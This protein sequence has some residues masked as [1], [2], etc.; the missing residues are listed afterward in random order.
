MVFIII[1]AIAAIFWFFQFN[2]I[3]SHDPSS[4]KDEQAEYFAVL[5]FKPTRKDIAGVMPFI[6][7]SFYIKNHKESKV[8]LVITLRDDKGVET[9]LERKQ[10]NVYYFPYRDFKKIILDKPIED[11]D[12]TEI[13]FKFRLVRPLESNE[14]FRV[15]KEDNKTYPQYEIP[16]LIY[17]DSVR[18]IIGEGKDRLFRD[19]K[20]AYFYLSSLLIIL[21]L[22]S[23]LFVIE[24]GDQAKIG[25]RKKWIPRV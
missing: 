6:D 11:K 14:W 2:Y 23:F 7:R 17:H 24:K 1:T 21:A 3:D 15:L 16:R 4:T 18:N 25:K 12:F 9:E 8:E 10:Y 22:I 19:R 5:S 20:F 13:L